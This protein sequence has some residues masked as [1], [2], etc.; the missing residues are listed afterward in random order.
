[1]KQ[2]PWLDP[3]D[4]I[5]VPCHPDCL[6]MAYALKVGGEVI[7]LT[8]LIDPEIL[9]TSGGSTI[10]YEQNPEL[11]KHIF[12]AFSTGHS[13]A[14]AALS[15]KQLLCCLPLVQVPDGL[16]YENIFRILIMQFLDSYN[17][18]VRSV[19]R[20]CVHIVHPDGRVIPF[21][22]FNMFYRDE[23]KEARLKE[24]KAEMA[25]VE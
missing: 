6:A 8:R 2:T 5:P 23:E 1:L 9:L 13:P 17:F 4:M 3:R 16:G 22:T 25:W 7:P 19:K 18:D 24:L 11:R 20:S 15:L 21:D 14:G 12:N 10:I